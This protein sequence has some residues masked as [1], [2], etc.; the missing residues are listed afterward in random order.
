MTV[1]AQIERGEVPIFPVDVGLANAQVISRILDQSGNEELHGKE[2]HLF[3][4]L[5][6]VSVINRKLV[7]NL[8]FLSVFAY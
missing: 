1:L 3:R 7:E 2:P 5:K 8:T 4:S 6:N